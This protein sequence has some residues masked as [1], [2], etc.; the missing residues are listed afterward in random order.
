MKQGYRSL[1]MMFVAL[2][3]VALTLAFAGQASAQ[4]ISGDVVGTILDKSGAAVPNASVEAVNADTGVKYSTQADGSGEYR[5]SNLPVGTYNISAWANNFAKTTVNS[6]RVELNKTT[7]LSIALE[8]KGAV[9]SIEVSGAAVALDT[10]T[11]QLSSTFEEQI[12]STLPSATAGSGVLNLS[13]LSSGVASSGGV[14]AGAGPSVGGQRPRNNNFTIEGV[15]NNSKSVTG[16]LV[17]IP[18]DAVAEF[19]V[20][21]NNFSAEFGHSSGGQF[22]TIVKSG[23]NSYHGM[24]YI[25]NQ[26]RNYFALD[27]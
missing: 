10:T 19:S 8:V 4:V 1:Y 26:N 24:A 3:V 22:N 7:T 9:T 13:L 18:N 15:D 25:Y 5:F 14:G 2:A 6:F 12:T 27:T 17:T 16:P 21:Q 11:S 23:T 20:L